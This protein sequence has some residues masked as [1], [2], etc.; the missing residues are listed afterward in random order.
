ML[1]YE[2][3]IGRGWRGSS[4][5]KSTCLS[6]RGPESSSQLRPFICA[7]RM[8]VAW[9]ARW[10]LCREGS[11]TNNLEHRDKGQC[12]RMKN[13]TKYKD[14]CGMYKNVTMK[15]SLCAVSVTFL[16]ALIKHRDQGKQEKGR[17]CLG[18]NIPEGWELSPLQREVW[19][20]VGVGTA[21]ETASWE[22][23]SKTTS[24][25]Q[26][27]NWEWETWKLAAHNTLPPA[28]PPVGNQV[29]KYL[30]LWGISHSNYCIT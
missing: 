11:V 9:E 25:Y 23:T 27:S 30:G 13:R 29:F 18:L 6:P 12:R 1:W 24:R 5:E 17:V 15:P 22:L 3:Q 16:M 2:K 21:L 10:V 28:M 14:R 20:K 26:R 19:Q 7:N 4:V 8:H